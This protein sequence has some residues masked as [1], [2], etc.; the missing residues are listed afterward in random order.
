MPANTATLFI[1][2]PTANNGQAAR[3]EPALQAALR[4]ASQPWEWARTQGHGHAVGLA[5]AAAQE[6]FRRVVALGGD[7]TVHE[8]L[9]G[10]MQAPPEQR[11]ELAVV[12]IGTGNDFAFAM[13]APR[14]PQAAVRWALDGVARPIDVGRV[15]D[16]LGR[17]AFW[18]NTFGIGFDAIVTI[19]SRVLPLR[20][21]ARYL[22]AVLQTIFLDHQPW[23]ARLVVDDQAE[24]AGFL[25]L[26]LCNGPREGGGF[27]IAPHA[28]PD[29]GLLHSLLVPGVSRWTMFRLLPE[30]M[31]G[32]QWRFPFIR[33]HA[34][35]R[36]EVHTDRG[37][38]IH[39]DGE[40]FA[41]PHDDVRRLRVEVL[42]AALAVVRRATPAEAAHAHPA[43]PP[44]SGR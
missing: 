2:N 10:L 40:I 4:D 22:V 13:G 16:N 9:N 24:E 7:G 41:A 5:H 39:M 42:P 17:T 29:D 15:H 1:F 35:R 38:A 28:R 36:L 33:G 18:G 12:P 44:A 6:G 23:Q 43:G 20:G 25:M 3:L 19:R 21:F 30:F 34:F 37:M 14:D 26:V 11:P 31:R 8:V 32:T 27:H